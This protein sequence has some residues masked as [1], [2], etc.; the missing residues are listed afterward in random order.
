M[1]SPPFD[2]GNTTKEGLKLLKFDDHRKAIFA[3]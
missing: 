2:I 1:V 3:I